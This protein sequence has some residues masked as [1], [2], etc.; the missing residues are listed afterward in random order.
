MSMHPGIHVLDNPETIRVI[1]DPVRLRLLELLRQQPRTVTELAELLDVPRTRLYYHVRLLEE[2]GLITVDDTRIVSGITE[3]RYR[4]TAYRF[5]VAK[6]LLGATGSD[7]SPLDVY[8]SVVLDEAA[9]EIRRAI[10]ADL[11]ELEATHED[12][13]RPRRLVIGRQWFR[14][15]DAE[16]EEFARRYEDLFSDFAGNAVLGHDTVGA[17]PTEGTLYEF[18]TSFYPVVPPSDPDSEETSNGN[19]T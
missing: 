14:F 8:L 5:S 6:S 12:A 11:I 7:T 18:L 9:A 17:G 4:V 15:T 16:L 10:D 2:H 19:D 3:K 13:F 1:A